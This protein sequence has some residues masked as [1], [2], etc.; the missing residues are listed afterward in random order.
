MF[1]FFI[2]IFRRR[3]RESTVEYNSKKIKSKIREKKFHLFYS[4]TCLDGEI[5]SIC[6]DDK[7]KN[8]VQLHSCGHIFHKKCLD[9]WLNIKPYCPLCRSELY[10]EKYQYETIV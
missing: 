10:I 6:L 9:T 2:R 7:N 5:C 4:H 3:N 8:V 1:E